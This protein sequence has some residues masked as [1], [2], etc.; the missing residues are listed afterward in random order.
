MID[1]SRKSLAALVVLAADVEPDTTSA[2]V[3]VRTLLSAGSDGAGLGRRLVDFAP[4][5]QFASVAGADGELCFIIKGSGRLSA[6]SHQEVPLRQDQGLLIP[7][8]LG[9]QVRA[10]DNT[11]LRLDVVSLPAATHA[12]GAEADPAGPLARHLSDCAVETTGD[13]KF[14]VVFGPGADCS[15]ATQFVGEIPP[16][17]APDHS[18]PYDET[19]LVLE[20]EGVVHIGGDTRA[21]EPGMCTHL[22]PGLSHCLENTGTTMLRVLGVFHPADSPASKLP[23]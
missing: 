13:R 14:R 18:H 11:E 6:G 12:A 1:K 17:K 20:G 21:L 9:Y 5:A 15:V 10:D 7:A 4:G 3:S 23:A 16:G 2:G 8:G 22:P 19:V